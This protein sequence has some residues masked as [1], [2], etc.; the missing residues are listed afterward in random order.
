MQAHAEGILVGVSAEGDFLELDAP[1]VASIGEGTGVV[2]SEDGLI[3]TAATSVV[4]SDRINVFLPG[5][6]FP[7]VAE[8]DAA[9][10]CVNLALIRVDHAF[11]KVAELGATSSPSAIA[12]AVGPA[13]A[14]SATTATAE[15]DTY[16]LPTSSRSNIGAILLDADGLTA[17]VITSYNDSGAPIALRGD[18]AD[19]WVRR[20]RS[21]EVVEQL[22]FSAVNNTEG[23]VVVTAV[24]PQGAGSTF[25]LTVGNVITKIDE[26]EIT[27]GLD[28][29]CDA[30]DGG[31]TMLEVNKEGRR[32]VG[33]FPDDSLVLASSRTTEQIRQ[34]VVEISTAADSRGTGF[35][36]SADGLVVTNYHVAGGY[37]DLFLRFDGSDQK[38]PARVIGG[39]GCADIAVL[40]AEGDAF[41]YLEWA[42]EAPT[43]EEP[44]RVVGFPNRTET[45]SFQDGAV[46]KEVSDDIEWFGF[47]TNFES[48]AK[49]DGGNSGSPVVNALGEVLGVHYASEQGGRSAILL[50]RH[51]VG[52]EAR[53][54]VDA[55]VSGAIIDPGFQPNGLLERNFDGVSGLTIEVADIS[56]T[57]AGTSL[58]LEALDEIVV[59]GDILPQQDVSGF[60]LI[61]DA[62]QGEQATPTDVVVWRYTDQSL[63]DGQMFGTPLTRRPE[64]YRL[65]SADG[66]I[67]AIIPGRWV[68]EDPVDV[69]GTDWV[70]FFAAE[71]LRGGPGSYFDDFGRGP[72]LRLMWSHEKSI[73][74]T[75]QAHLEGLGYASSATGPIRSF[76]DYGLSG[77]F[78]RYEIGGGA[79]VEY[80]VTVDGDPESPLI[81]VFVADAAHR[82]DATVS[83]LLESLRLDIPVFVD[84]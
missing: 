18:V 80:A 11:E 35:L 33:S 66:T 72:G 41:Q 36:V 5:E 10:E 1:G 26:V 57:G 62:L 24:A 70:G 65:A 27:G 67:S 64:P 46:S 40:Q 19:L 38:I 54:I 2:V 68:D 84:G 49:T 53:E 78:Q 37:S 55:I 4:G 14:S 25:G 31:S 51:L 9:A 74:H 32:H 13:V 50:P 3:L 21:R 82:I 71:R 43:L 39:S 23:Q 52:V 83:R 44:V 20:M 81:M 76:S 73:T 29:L 63:Y 16:A 75:T 6:E 8:L 28:Q 77:H 69:T 61:C 58:G 7:L 59:F 56:P 48:S 34:A 17:G 12:T 45:I 22:G 30:I 60:R 47:L 15:G 79:A 42:P